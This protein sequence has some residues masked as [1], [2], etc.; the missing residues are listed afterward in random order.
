VALTNANRIHAL[1]GGTILRLAIGAQ[2]PPR[3]A[4]AP[5]ALAL[6]FGLPPTGLIGEIFELGKKAV[7]GGISADDV[8]HVEQEGKEAASAA[9]GLLK[10]PPDT[11]PP[12][13]I[14]AIRASFE[15]TLKEMGVTLVVLIDDLDRCLPA[16]TISTLEAIRLFLFL[17]NTA[18][19]IAAD[20]T[21]IK[22]AVRSHFNGVDETLVINYFDKLIQ[23]PIRVPPLGTQ[24]VRAYMMLL[25]VENSTLSDT[26]KEAIRKKVCAQLGQSWKNARVDRAFM[27]TLHSGYPPELVARF[28]TADRL[29]PIMTTASQIGGN[30]RLIKRFLNALSIRMTIARGHDVIVD[31]AALTKMLLFERCAPPAAYNA[32]AKAV[33]A[34]GDGILHFSQIGKTRLLPVKSST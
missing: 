32:L 6:A 5:S 15:A 3:F 7:R 18:F 31:E 19:V 16:T 14:Q 25:F 9:G 20:E 17:Q 23:V 27:M 33:N 4:I 21:M 24:E 10:P 11:S 13:E 26:D 29:A 28:E 1:G 12:K 2:I 8:S 30:P 34:S 22:H